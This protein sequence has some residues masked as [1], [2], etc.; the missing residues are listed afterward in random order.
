[1]ANL[2]RAS[3]CHGVNSNTNTQNR[4]S[5][6]SPGVIVLPP[7]LYLC[8]LAAA[9]ALHFIRPIRFPSPVM[10][11]IIG[12]VVIVGSGILVAWGAATMRRAGTNIRP[13]QPTLAIVMDGPFRFTRNPL[14]IALTGFYVGLALLI[15]TTWPFLLL[16]VVQ[17]FMHWGVVRREERYLEGKFG[18][19]YLDYKARVRR[20]L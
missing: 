1:M 20:W 5:L 18:R 7:V 3:I 12:A 11:R 10:A 9:V 2:W 13:D 6:D 15:N 4:P 19:A 14:Y 8:A 17:A 16:P